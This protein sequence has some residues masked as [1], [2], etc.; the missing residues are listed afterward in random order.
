[1]QPLFTIRPTAESIRLD[2]NGWGQI[3]FA[4]S[5]EAPRTVHARA[6]VVPVG[7]THEDWLSLAGS[8]ERDFAPGQSQTFTVWV[9]VPVGSPAAPYGLRL[10][11]A[12]MGNP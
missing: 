4:V 12:S 11:L 7:P 6:R 3:A 1:M 10:E 9:S 2:E 5:C 8:A